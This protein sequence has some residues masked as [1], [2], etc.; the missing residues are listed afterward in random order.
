[1]FLA[2]RTVGSLNDAL[3]FLKSLNVDDHIFAVNEWSI[4]SFKVNV[5]SK[6]FQT[7]L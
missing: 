3:F 7:K 4:R 5:R 1:M 2:Q 6:S